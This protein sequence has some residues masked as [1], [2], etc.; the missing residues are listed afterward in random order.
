[1]DVSEYQN[2]IEKTMRAL[3]VDFL[4]I[5]TD[6]GAVKKFIIINKGL[7]I[8]LSWPKNFKLI[9]DNHIDD[10]LCSEQF[11]EP[12][13]KILCC[14]ERLQV[15]GY[16]TKDVRNPIN[17]D[18]R[19]LVGEG[20][21]FY[22]IDPLNHNEICRIGDTPDSFFKKGMKRFYKFYYKLSEYEIGLS[23]KLEK[24]NNL[25][26][27]VMSFDM[28][29]EF[30]DAGNIFEIPFKF[31]HGDTLKFHKKKDSFL[32]TSKINIDLLSNLKCIGSFGPK[33]FISEG[34]ISLYASKYGCVYAHNDNNGKV[35]FLAE[36]YINF[37][38][39]GVIPY[40]KNFTFSL[41]KKHKPKI[42]CP[43]T[44]YFK[45][46]IYKYSDKDLILLS[47]L[48]DNFGCMI[49]DYGYVFPPAEDECI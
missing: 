47:Y 28:I 26:H 1:M 38:K 49:N 8:P 31:V 32:E 13:S 45:R 42:P 22:S 24:K 40:Y 5:Y 9:I 2:N 44:A 11:I 18:Y 48:H 25:F 19:I 37:L 14:P 34:R 12:W 43:K 10:S 20:G 16:V 7:V 35:I 21:R 3:L 23:I 29:S 4:R 41:Y 27:T 46:K 15:F 6:Y 39:I 33:E 36:G 17:S 30:V